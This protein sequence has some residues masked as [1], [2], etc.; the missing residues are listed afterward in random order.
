M[1]HTQWPHTHHHHERISHTDGDR[2]TV[3]TETLPL[4]IPGVDLVFVT[5]SVL[6]EDGASRKPSYST[7]EHQLVLR[8]EREGGMGGGGNGEGREQMGKKNLTR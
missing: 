4:T 2:T 7:V 5:C 3:I 6:R 8:R 1:G